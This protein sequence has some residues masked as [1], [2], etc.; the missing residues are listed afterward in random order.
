MMFVFRVI[1]TT[2]YSHKH[3]IIYLKDTLQVSTVRS[4]NLSYKKH[5][6]FYKLF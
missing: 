1:S 4:K 5:L 3:Y 2:G 6:E